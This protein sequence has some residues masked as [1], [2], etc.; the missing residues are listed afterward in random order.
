MAYVK[1]TTTERFQEK[2]AKLSSDNKLDFTTED[3]NVLQ[4]RLVNAYN[5][6]FGVLVSRGL[7]EIQIS[8]WIR[9]E[10]FQLD[11]ATYWYAKDSGWGGKSYD[12][13]DWTKVFNREKELSIIA[14]ISN[15]GLVL[16]K[17]F[18][19]VTSGLNLLEINEALGYRP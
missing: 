18:G 8:T 1:Y 5:I 3:T 19:T 9:G 7:T 2:L 11:I 16:V 6:I 10:E 13:K 17:G 12:E 4:R 14:V 15:E